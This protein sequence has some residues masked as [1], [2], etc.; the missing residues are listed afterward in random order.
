M[1]E[2]ATGECVPTCGNSVLA[3]SCYSMDIKC[4]CSDPSHV[5]IE[6]VCRPITDCPCDYDDNGQ[7]GQLEVTL[8]HF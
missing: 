7:V 6:G 5:L 2:E 4:R 8:I 3:D 1:Y